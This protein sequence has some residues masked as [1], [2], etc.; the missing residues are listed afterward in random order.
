MVICERPNLEI[1]RISSTFGS[2]PRACSSGAVIC[3]ST[4][5]GA[6]AAATVL[7]WTCVGVV[8]GNASIGRS[9][10]A[11]SPAMTMASQL[12]KTA[13]RCRR[14]QSIILVSTAFSDQSSAQPAPIES[15]RISVLRRNA[16]VVTTSAP[17]ETPAR[18]STWFPA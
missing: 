10:K 4:S 6:S 16:P 5:S 7:I 8:S 18:T 13:Q 1:E 15:L 11:T 12:S 14:A 9:R 17:E 2:P 3:R